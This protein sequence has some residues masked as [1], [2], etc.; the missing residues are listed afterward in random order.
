MSEVRKLAAGV[1]CAGFYGTALTHEL[2]TFLRDVPL[3]GVVL[4][5]G[6]IGT[7]AQVRALTDALRAV[8][9]QP[10]VAIDQEGGR[11][12]RIRDGVEEIPSALAIAAACAGAGNDELARQ[13]GEQVAFDLRRAGANVDFAP[14][15][16]LALTR[17]NTVIGTRAFGDDPRRV[18]ELAGAFAAGLEAGGVAATFKHFP[19]HGS[20]SA[21]SHLELPVID[22]DE[23]TLRSRD[24]IPFAQLLPSARAV[25]TAHIVARAFEAGR[26]ATVSR[27][28][29]TDL[30]RGELHFKGVCFTDCLQMDAIAKGIGTERAG[31]EALAAGADCVLVSHDLE[32]AARTVDGIARAAESGELPLDRLEEAAARVLRLRREL[33][34]PLPLE[35]SAPFPGIGARIGLSAVTSI[36]GEVRAGAN[37]VAV[38]FESPTTEGAQGLHD[39]HPALSGYAGVREVRAPLDP[40]AEETARVV[41]EIDGRRPI[42]LTRRAHVYAGQ[43]AAVERIL[44][45]HPDALLVSL[46]EPFDAF[47]FPQARNVACTYGDD[48]PSISG[49]AAVLFDGKPAAGVFPLNGAALARG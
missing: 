28:I 23:V 20:T 38:S 2:H 21:D 7:V 44:D 1:V 47:E 15:A 37:D 5:G 42:V 35:A 32:L 39:R 14:V 48:A 11:V 18:A 3:A 45:A 26:P 10:I 12:A 4:F 13:A 29:L 24:L 8:L 49:L 34:P 46:R 22:D 9:S 33:Q 16:D 43:K 30:L 25:M 27:R 41:G 17:M 6:N 31:V 19:G 40:A 36:R